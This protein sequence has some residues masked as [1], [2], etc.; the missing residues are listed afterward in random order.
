VLGVP[1]GNKAAGG[2]SATRLSLSQIASAVKVAVG[3]SW[4]GIV[5]I[6]TTPQGGALEVRSGMTQTRLG[7]VSTVTGSKTAIG[8]TQELLQMLEQTAGR[9]IA[10]GLSLTIVGVLEQVGGQRVSAGSTMEIIRAYI[11]TTGIS[12]EII[13]AVEITLPLLFAMEADR[14]L[15]FTQEVTRDLLF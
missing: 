3:T 10:A 1:A 14:D 8:S 15:I 12:G 4:T 6:T 13:S 5:V 9:K 2:I 7:I 11:V